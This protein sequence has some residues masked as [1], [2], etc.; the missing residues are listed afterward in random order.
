[1]AMGGQHHQVGTLMAERVVD[2][3]V[4]VANAHE[5]GG[6]QARKVVDGELA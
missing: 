6:L 3:L 1:M 2:D 5:H 4:G